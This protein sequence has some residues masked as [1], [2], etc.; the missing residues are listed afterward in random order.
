M[1]Y[2]LLRDVNLTMQF[3]KQLPQFSAQIPFFNKICALSTIEIFMQH[4]NNKL[5]TIF[6]KITSKIETYMALQNMWKLVL[7]D[8]FSHQNREWW[9]YGKF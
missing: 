3:L 2:N 4:K 5:D 7:L 1:E 6:R 8:A 9:L